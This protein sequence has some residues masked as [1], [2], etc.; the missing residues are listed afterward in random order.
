MEKSSDVVVCGAVQAGRGYIGK[1]R[2]GMGSAGKSRQCVDARE[3][4]G[5]VCVVRGSP[6]VL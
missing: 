3:S 1:F 6:A 5:R 4:L 2:Q